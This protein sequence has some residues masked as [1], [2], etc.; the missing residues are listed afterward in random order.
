MEDT[1]P[2][3]II[4]VIGATPPFQYE[5][6]LEDATNSDAPTTPYD[7]IRTGI[8]NTIEEVIACFEWGLREP[9]QECIREKLRN[10][11]GVK[12]SLRDAYQ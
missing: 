8:Y 11:T 6:S 7:N 9:L 2:T 10:G 5:V 3:A 1:Y 12:F 4:K